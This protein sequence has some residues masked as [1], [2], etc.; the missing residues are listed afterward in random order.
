V[1]YGLYRN[2]RE[3][4]PGSGGENDEIHIYIVVGSISNK[5][6]RVCIDHEGV[7]S[8]MKKCILYVVLIVMSQSV[9]ADDSTFLCKQ[10][11]TD[12]TYILSG[13]SII[14]KDASGNYGKPANASF[15]YTENGLRFWTDEDALLRFLLVENQLI[16]MDAL[17]TVH[18]KIICE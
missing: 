3:S 14:S 15:D 1:G 5:A 11:D 4:R 6:W 18:G 12:T 8:V 9:L 13:T 16:V 10:I 17:N 2:L 7:K